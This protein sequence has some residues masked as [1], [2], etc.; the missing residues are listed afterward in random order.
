[1]EAMGSEQTTSF[2]KQI[3]LPTFAAAL[4]AV[5]MMAMSATAMAGP[6]FIKYGMRDT[7]GDRPGD[8]SLS[9]AA[10]SGTNVYTDG[11]DGVI[12]KITEQVGGPD[13]FSLQAFQTSSGGRYLRLAIPGVVDT[14]CGYGADRV[15]GG[16]I[17]Q[18][19]VG[20][21]NTG[22]LGLLECYESANRRNGWKV[23]VGNCITIAH[24]TATHWQ[25]RADIGCTG[26]VYQVVKGKA[27]SLGFHGI[28][29]QID[30]DQ[31]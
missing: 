3:K 25:F 21:V 30:A 8:V 26:H 11:D 1:M 29:F 27:T 16:E 20:S 9:D 2:M 7:L 18:M 31:L 28:T 10:S 24:T 23:D 13:A 15:H 5:A 6:K 19:V 12:S 4:M 22:F 17:Y 14:S